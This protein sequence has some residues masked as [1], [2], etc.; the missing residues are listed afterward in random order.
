FAVLRLRG[1]RIIRPSLKARSRRSRRP[2]RPSSGSSG[3]SS[4]S[5]LRA[6]FVSNAASPSVS[7]SDV[8]SGAGRRKSLPG[9]AEKSRER[10]SPVV[11][12]F[13]APSQGF[14]QLGGA[15]PPQLV[16]S[17]FT[18]QGIFES[19]FFQSRML[20]FSSACCATA[21][22]RGGGRKPKSWY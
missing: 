14:Q 21:S 12:T 13:E 5:G 11:P 3:G 16:K 20:G 1:V 15:Q 6:A 10:S 8:L 2:A 17:G 9:T 19:R 22:S 4:I 7:S 18:K